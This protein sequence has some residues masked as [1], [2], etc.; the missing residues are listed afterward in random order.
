MFR[1]S[2]LKWK[3]RHGWRKAT[4]DR[5]LE[6]EMRFHM[7]MLEQESGNAARREFG[8]RATLFEDSRAAWGW[9]WA[10]TF[11]Q[12]LRFAWRSFRRDWPSTT[13]A[14]SALSLGIGF[15]IAVGK[16]WSTSNVIVIGIL[17]LPPKA[18]IGLSSASGPAVR[19]S[20]LLSLP[21]PKTR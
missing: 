1:W 19:S 15:S 3:I 18:T 11:A 16:Y 20:P 8:N 14:V 21:R 12:D 9:T 5:E 4:L 2:R 6:E 17:A 7:E 10:E 13:A